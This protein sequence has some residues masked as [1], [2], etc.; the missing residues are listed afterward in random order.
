MLQVH[1]SSS[2]QMHGNIDT[3][4][5]A[6]LKV[7]C[8]ISPV[9]LSIGSPPSFVLKRVLFGGDS[10]HLFIHAQ[11]RNFTSCECSIPYNLQ[12]IFFSHV[13]VSPAPYQNTMARSDRGAELFA[14]ALIPYTAAAI[15]L[16]LRNVA[17]RNTR[18]VMFWEDYLAI[19]AFVSLCTS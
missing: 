13:T 7:S 17:R 9:R 15:A 12:P 2:S 10:F 16:V 3:H 4:Y 11:Q 6:L 19:V 14:A 18:V 1:S 8:L 5:T